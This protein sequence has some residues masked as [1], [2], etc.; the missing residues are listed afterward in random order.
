[1]NDNTFKNS[2][3]YNLKEAIEYSTG[4][5]VSKIITKNEAGNVSLFAF[6]KD[7]SLSEHTA[8][9]DALVQ[10]IEGNASIFINGEEISIN[11]GEIIIMPAKI[12]HAVEARSK[13]KM[14]LTMVKAKQ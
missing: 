8:P 11:E 3:I 1:M 4:A 10:V 5:I 6:D 2:K 7:Q 9:F 13:F 14:M 12:S